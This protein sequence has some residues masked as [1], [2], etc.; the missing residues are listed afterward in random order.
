M[1]KQYDADLSLFING[2]WRI[3]EGRDAFPVVDPA[4]GET[5]AEVRMASPADLDEALNA[6][7][8]GFAIWR[9]TPVDQ[10]AAV[11]RRAAALLRE[12]AETIARLLT[13]E[14]GK[15]IAEARAE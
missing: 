12:R 3:G 5:I 6:A 13:T 1:D 2:S 14:Q 9:D 11:L 15:P 8:K 4:R 7:E 10:R